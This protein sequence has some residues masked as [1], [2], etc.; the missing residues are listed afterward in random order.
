MRFWMA[1]KL[2]D[3]KKLGQI[4]KSP[5]WATAFKFKAEEAV[6]QVNDIV[7]QVGRTGAI[8]PVAELKPVRVGGVEI[9]RATLHNEDEI[10]RLG[11]KIGDTVLVKRAGDVIPD[12]V[13]VLTKKTPKVAVTSP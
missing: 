2:A 3:Q 8:T 9:R 4:A 13:S 11:L 1:A 5:R 12:V 10:K 6:T 7:L